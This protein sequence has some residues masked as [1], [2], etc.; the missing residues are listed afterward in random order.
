[1][2][3][4][5]RHI[6]VA[7]LLMGPVAPLAAQPA[8]PDT[9]AGRRLAEAVALVNDPTDAAVRSYI[10]DAYSEAFLAFAPVDVHA[11]YYYRLHDQTRGV[12]LVGIQASEPTRAVALL[13]ARLTGEW[14]A[15]GVTVDTTRAHRIDRIG[16]EMPE[17]PP[18]LAEPAPATDAERARR[19]A[20]F[21]TSSARPTCLRRGPPRPRRLGAGAGGDGRGGPR[22]WRAG[23]ARDPVRHRLDG[24]DVGRR[25]RPARRGGTAVV[26]RPAL[27][28]PAGLPDAAAARR[29][30]I[31]HLLSHTSGLG[32]YFNRPAYLAT[33]RSARTVDEMLGWAEG[34]TLLFEPG[35]DWRYSNVG[36]LALGKVIEAVTGRSYFDVVRER[37]FE[38][39]GMT[40]TGFDEAARM[41]SDVAV[42]YE[43]EYASDGVRYRRTTSELPA[44]GGPA[45]GAVSTAGDLLRFARALQ[46][47][48]L[49]RPATLARLT[50]PKP[51][52]GSPD[53]GFG[54]ELYR[55]GM[56]GHSGSFPGVSAGLEVYP[57]DGLV[58][59]I[60]SNTGGAAGPVLRKA[61]SLLPPPDA[62]P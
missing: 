35:T 41:G 25:H 18:E 38:P 19:L 51:A 46:S 39:A 31:E 6:V 14:L 15:L 16:Q 13:R 45:G 11:A 22:R 2:T 9:P 53:Y 17:V 50:S 21:S 29:I 52:L 57:A 47:G 33:R 28:R 10:A 4:L 62:A 61:W 20:A 48:A 7:A 55:P 43:K 12:D 49:V 5:H 58:L 27:R 34:D 26:R 32:D 8:T 54:F 3:I 23:H 24:E 56:V 42:G 60:L 37:V 40:Q 44:R 36:F 59:V 1:M 30:R